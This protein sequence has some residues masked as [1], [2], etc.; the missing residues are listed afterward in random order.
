MKANLAPVEHLGK[1]E[2]LQLVEDLWD[3]F[4]AESAA[5][6]RPEVLDELERRAAWRDS[7]PDSSQSLA[8]LSRHIS[9]QF[10]LIVIMRNFI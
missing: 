10:R 6:T 8:H 3:E 1:F 5:E 7:H 4:A 9:I 2:R